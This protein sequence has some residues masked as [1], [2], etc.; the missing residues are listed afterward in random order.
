[1]SHIQPAPRS[2]TFP[3]SPFQQVQIKLVRRP[4]SVRGVREDGERGAA[5]HI[6]SEHGSSLRSEQR[7]DTVNDVNAALLKFYSA[8]RLGRYILTDDELQ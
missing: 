3:L 7:T 6:H 1:M 5:L 4:G 8:I 2:E